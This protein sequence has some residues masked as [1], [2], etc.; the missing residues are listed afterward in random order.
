MAIAKAKQATTL[1]GNAYTKEKAYQGVY[2]ENDHPLTL[3]D[4]KHWVSMCEGL[5]SGSDIEYAKAI[6]KAETI[7]ET[8]S[9]DVNSPRNKSEFWVHGKTEEC[10]SFYDMKDCG[11]NPVCLKIK[12][13]L[14]SETTTTVTVTAE[15]QPK[16][17]D[18]CFGSSNN[19][20]IKIYYDG[21]EVIIPR[22]EF[23]ANGFKTNE[24]TVNKS[25]PF[26][27]DGFIIWNREDLMF[28]LQNDYPTNGWKTTAGVVIDVDC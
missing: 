5:A 24:F 7:N 2:P 25:I 12:F 16:L 27:D 20:P 8:N 22:S 28:E 17:L 26:G 21:N 1:L 11:A 14:I 10:G 9:S 23:K 6:Q 15:I 18:I 19:D 13:C 4:Y 3:K